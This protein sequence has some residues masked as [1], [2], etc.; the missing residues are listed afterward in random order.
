MFGENLQKQIDEI[1]QTAIFEKRD[2]V[3]V[4]DI[5]YV[6]DPI[7]IYLDDKKEEYFFRWGI[8]Q[9]EVIQ[10]N[11]EFGYVVVR[12]GD[13]DY[14]QVKKTNIWTRYE[15]A[16]VYALN[17]DIVS[18]TDCVRVLYNRVVELKDTKQDGVVED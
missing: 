10:V 7:K 18:L 12:I 4:G 14:K 15:N 8:N 6:L 3:K 11:D 13:K 9:C 5:V 2:L 16:L 1:K 17:Q